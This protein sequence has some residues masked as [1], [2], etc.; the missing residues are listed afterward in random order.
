[1]NA[2]LARIRPDPFTLL[3]IAIAIAG[4]GLVLARQLTYGVELWGDSIAYISTA[5]ALL[6]GEGLTEIWDGDWLYRS[7]PPLYPMLLAAGSLGLFD[8]WD[9]A[10][11]LNAVCHGLT[12][13]VAG[14]W[15]RRYVRSPMLVI[16][17]S[18]AIALSLPLISITGA[19]IA[20]AP[21]YLLSTLALSRF[22][23][24]SEEPKRSTLLQVAVLTALACLTRYVGI[25]LLPVFVLL[26]L[27]QRNTSTGIKAKRIVGYFLISA[28]P[29]ALYLIRNYF[30]FGTFT[31]NFREEDRQHGTRNVL[32]ILEENIQ[33]IG[34]WIVP[35]MD[36]NEI[37][38]LVLP[39]FLI[40]SVM[41]GFVFYMK[42]K[43]GGYPFLAYMAIYFTIVIASLNSGATDQGFEERFTTAL[44]I[45]FICI[46]AVTIDG[47]F[48][49]GQWSTFR[50]P[51]NIPV[52]G[53]IAGIVIIV[54]LPL[55]AW[56]GYSA[57]IN[58]EEIRYH[59]STTFYREWESNSEILPYIESI[60]AGMTWGN[61]SKRDVYIQTDKGRSEYKYLPIAYDDLPE[62]IAGINVGDSIIWSKYPPLYAAT[63]YT[64]PELLASEGLDFVVA[65]RDGYVIRV[66]GRTHAEK[67]AT[68]ISREPDIVSDFDVYFSGRELSWVRKPCRHSE[69]EGVVY[70]HV[71]PRNVA[72]IPD[73][74][75][76]SG[77]D[78]LDFR[79]PY[80]G[81]IFD[82]TCMATIPLP[83]YQITTIFTG[84]YSEGELLWSGRIDPPID[85]SRVQAD[86]DA[87]TAG[88]P[89]A[90]AF[91]SIW[92]DGPYISYTRE[93]CEEADTTALFFLHVYPVDADDLPAP[94][95]SSQPGVDFDNLDFVFEPA[96][97]SV[98]FDGKCIATRL[99]PDYPIASIHTGQYDA[100]GTVWSV[101]IPFD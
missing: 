40:L 55:Y 97:G 77:F 63:D 93:P 20:E 85:D 64:F 4:T 66:S 88:N 81:V 26:I 76:R 83:D 22:S 71:F 44:Y 21:F 62:F 8:P 12:V 94:D 33:Y 90:Q 35:E 56:L 89:A 95:E 58:E 34:G 54:A 18:L 32:G 27:L 74:R 11:P 9:V 1:M 49:T 6:A 53:G 17:G 16:W 99:L 67:Y 101:D 91:Y 28:I 7:W 65:L 92:I 87:V 84:Q 14:Q 47:F 50:I 15:L 72:N 70:V 100:S 30:Y 39:I 36:I 48:S 79:F 68:I 5:R 59:N 25:A 37:A 10:G 13:L 23:A 96:T 73:D 2:Y 31:T 24:W 29:I 61:L 69:I 80:A 98:R 42:K 78:V 46:M 52:F 82:G 75:K 57:K 51:E 3:L 43:V 19:A 41:T 60:R 38:H 45:P 86:Y